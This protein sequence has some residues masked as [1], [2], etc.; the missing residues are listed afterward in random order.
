MAEDRAAVL[1]GLLDD[2]RRAV[3]MGARDAAD[4]TDGYVRRN[5]WEALGVAA[6]A[7]L[8]AYAS[9]HPHA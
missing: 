8:S 3:K 4:A 5:P 6:A 7:L 1:P 2:A 9:A